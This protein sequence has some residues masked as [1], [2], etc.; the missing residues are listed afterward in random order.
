M[1]LYACVL[2]LVCAL[3]L[4]CVEEQWVCVSCGDFNP[5]TLY[6]ECSLNSLGAIMLTRCFNIE[7]QGHYLDD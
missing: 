4:P 1:P 3:D 7:G 2:W 5:F 6:G